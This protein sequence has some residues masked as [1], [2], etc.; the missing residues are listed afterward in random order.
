MS[1]LLLASLLAQAAPPSGPATRLAEVMH[2]DRVTPGAYRLIMFR[3][4][5]DSAS[6]FVVVKRSVE[7]T[8]Y[9]GKPAIRVREENRAQAS[10]VTI[11]IDAATLRPLSYESTAGD[12]MSVTA[13]M[14]GDSMRIVRTQG[15]IVT[16]SVSAIDPDVYFSNSFAELVQ[17]NDFA[18][19]PRIRFTTLTPGATANTFIVER[20]GRRTFEHNIAVWVLKFTR[21][22]AT[23]A[24]TPAGY[25]YVDA[26]TG[27]VLF[28]AT[29]LD[30]PSTYSYQVLPFH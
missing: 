5:D 14:D 6:G 15:G 28:F 12:T 19:H 7:R 24:S 10:A 22:D 29:E 3:T 11:R 17:A 8:E 27:A 23:G 18:K 26:R 21:T 20:V 30:S 2:A 1:L 25:R 4:Q 9:L 16:R 13:E